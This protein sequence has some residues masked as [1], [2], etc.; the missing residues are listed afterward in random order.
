MSVDGRHEIRGDELW[1]FRLFIYGEDTQKWFNIAGVCMIST[2]NHCIEG[3]RGNPMCRVSVDDE[4]ISISIP[5]GPDNVSQRLQE[6]ARS[7]LLY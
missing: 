1:S 7:V 5:L 3:V 4:C 6:E 2:I